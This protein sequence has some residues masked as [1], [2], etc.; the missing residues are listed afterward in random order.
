MRAGVVREAAFNMVAIVTVSRRRL[1]F[2]V[3]LA[4]YRR[5]MPVTQIRV[6]ASGDA[7]CVCPRC[8]LTLEREYMS[9][10][11]R[12]GQHLG[13]KNLEYAEITNV[14]CPTTSAACVSTNA[15]INATI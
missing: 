9:F 14:P 10:C 8:K 1:N 6:Y 4:K 2:L 3:D 11:D 7:Y 15:A 12:C 5:T 13:W